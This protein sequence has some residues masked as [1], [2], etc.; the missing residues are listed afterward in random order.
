[1]ARR[2]G[3]D[4]ARPEGGILESLDLFQQACSHLARVARR[5]RLPAPMKANMR[6]ITSVLERST[7]LAIREA[8]KQVRS[9]K[10]PTIARWETSVRR[11]A[12]RTKLERAVKLA[13]KDEIKKLIEGAKKWLP[14]PDNWKDLI[15]ELL[16]LINK[17]Q[18]L[19]G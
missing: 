3:R 16:H 10:G 4:I 12:V 14:I 15:N 8:K 1:M 7:P 5:E 18:R 19:L 6:E 2:R 11:G 13:T 9:A 17:I